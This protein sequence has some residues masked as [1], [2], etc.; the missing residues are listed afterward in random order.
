MRRKLDGTCVFCGRLLPSHIE[1]QEYEA[2][3][4][5]PRH[6]NEQG[7]DLNACASGLMRLIRTLLAQAAEEEE[8]EADA[9]ARRLLRWLEADQEQ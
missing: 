7:A 9:T 5:K 2:Y 8:Q 1:T 6:W 4:D 3:C